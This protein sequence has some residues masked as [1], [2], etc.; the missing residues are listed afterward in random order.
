ME[1]GNVNIA[2]AA[3]HA[4]CCPEGA[5]RNISVSAVQSV[6]Y[7]SALSETEHGAF[8]QVPL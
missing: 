6:R 2:D 8:P 3:S 1:F 5:E 4:C 7:Q